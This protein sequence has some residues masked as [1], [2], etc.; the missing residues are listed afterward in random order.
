[1]IA[2]KHEDLSL[3]LRIHV[4]TNKTKTK[5]RKKGAAARNCNNRTGEGDKRKVGLHLITGK[6]QD[7]EASL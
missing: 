4:I 5:Q 3:V 1:M 6:L 2:F 7:S